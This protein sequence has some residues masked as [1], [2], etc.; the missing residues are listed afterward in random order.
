MVMMEEMI[1]I[2]VIIS[3]IQ[4]AYASKQ[5]SQLMASGYTCFVGR[6]VIKARQ[7]LIVHFLRSSNVDRPVIRVLK[8]Y[9]LS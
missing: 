1:F 3:C 5:H 4:Y 2:I 9:Y 7:G 8:L 6:M